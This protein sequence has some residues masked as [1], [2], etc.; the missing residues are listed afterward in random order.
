MHP[1]NAACQGAETHSSWGLCQDGD[2]VL[3]VFAPFRIS[4]RDIMHLRRSGA[5]VQTATGR[6]FRQ[7]KSG[8]HHCHQ[9]ST[10]ISMEMVPYSAVRVWRV[11]AGFLL[12]TCGMVSDAMWEDRPITRMH[13]RSREGKVEG[14]RRTLTNQMR[15]DKSPLSMPRREIG[16]RQHSILAR[17]NR[18]KATANLFSSCSFCTLRDA[19]DMWV[20][21]NAR[22]LLASPWSPNVLA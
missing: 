13:P 19:L 21:L 10:N 6:V 17:F 20:H 5:L 22:V 1:D 12:Q 9:G 7:H 18:K 8:L 2:N 14:G 15:I 16:L 3:P 11:F 4:W